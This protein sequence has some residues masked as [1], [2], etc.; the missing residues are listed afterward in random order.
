[1]PAGTCDFRRTGGF[2]AAATTLSRSGV[3]CL[4]RRRS[5]DGTHFDDHAVIQ[6]RTR[7][8]RREGVVERARIQHNV[9]A[10]NLLSLGKGTV[11]DDS[12]ADGAAED[13]ARELEAIRGGHTILLMK[14]V[15]PCVE[16]RHD[17]LYFRRRRRSG[18][19][20][21]F[22]EEKVLTNG[23]GR[24]HVKKGSII[25]RTSWRKTDTF[26]RLFLT[27]GH[28]FATRVAGFC[29]DAPMERFA[30]STGTEVFVW[31]GGVVTEC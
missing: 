25:R 9:T 23:W 22:E 8:S 7:A 31:L 1:M 16:A 29:G 3:G 2:F 27:G 5:F 14:T 18:A 4:L 17:Y 13:F 28:F 30:I 10:H 19:G 24:S 20:G 15:H 21:V 12:F 6:A 11:R 26:S